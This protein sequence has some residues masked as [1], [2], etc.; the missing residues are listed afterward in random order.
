MRFASIKIRRLG[1]VFINRLG[2]LVWHKH[3]PATELVRIV[4]AAICVTTC[5]GYLC[6][7]IAKS[8]YMEIT[9]GKQP[10][11][12]KNA[13]FVVP[14]QD[15]GLDYSRFLHTSQKHASLSCNSCHVRSDNSA[16]PR[17]PGHKA[18]FDCHVT[19]FTTAAVPMCAICHTD[20]NSSNPPLKSFPSRFNESFNVKFDH[21][22]HNSGAGRPPSGCSSCHTRLG[23]RPA[24]LSIPAGMSAHNQCYTCHTPGSKNNAGREMASC[25]VCHDSKPYSRTTVNARAYRYSFSHAKHGRGQRLDCAD[26]HR[27][28]AGL[29]QSRQVSSPVVSEHFPTTRGMACSTCHNGKRSFGGDLAFKD[30]R[31]CHSAATF[32][33]PL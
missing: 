15:P 3:V 22:Q 31:R 24:A 14:A 27:L 8:R 30:C 26:C 28:T 5:F 11:Y 13:I 17:F 12:G 19:Q 9:P 21:V 18:C 33:M 4:V 25:G 6:V 1:K 2:V 32:R 7:S 20:V 10:S 23:R 29:P 16:T